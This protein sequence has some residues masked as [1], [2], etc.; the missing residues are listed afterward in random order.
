MKFNKCFRVTNYNVAMLWP[1]IAHYQKALIFAIENSF[2]FLNLVLSPISSAIFA[3][4]VCS[5]YDDGNYLTAQLAI[6]C[7]TNEYM[8][9]RN[10]AYV[11]AFVFPIG[12][13]CSMFCA[14]WRS[15]KDIYHIMSIRCDEIERGIPSLLQRTAI[16][17]AEEENIES[18]LTLSLTSLF[19]DFKPSFFWY[20]VRMCAH[21]IPIFFWILVH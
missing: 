17:I 14:L 8:R 3:T 18:V 7:D 15:R 19:E 16:Q 5:S 2:L 4:F 13:P 10:Y 11:A 21:R 12:V 1:A 9:W 6:S 20:H